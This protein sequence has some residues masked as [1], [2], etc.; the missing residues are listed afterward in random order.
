MA[1]LALGAASGLQLSRAPIDLEY[2]RRDG[3][4]LWS[5][6]QVPFSVF[7]LVHA[8][9]FRIISSTLLRSPYAN[10]S[11]HLSNPLTFPFFLASRQFLFYSVTVP[12]LSVFHAT[13]DLM[14]FSIGRL[15]PRYALAASTLFLCGWAVQLGFWTQCDLPENLDTAT[16][17]MQTYIRRNP[18]GG[19]DLLGISEGLARSKVA[20]GFLVLVL[21][22]AYLSVA[23]AAV[24]KQRKQG[25]VAVS[26]PNGDEY[27]LSKA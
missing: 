7:L 24:H 4:H 2:L 15:H 20:F 11:T 10:I 27:E 13:F 26:R 5:T 22:A 12:F 3:A 21:Y 25:P 9:S 23:A 14:A 1:T 8:N 17:C 18:R 6:G 19:P 16:T